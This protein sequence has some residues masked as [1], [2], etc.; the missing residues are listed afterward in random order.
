MV[1]F[2]TWHSEILRDMHKMYKAQRKNPTFCRQIKDDRHTVLGYNTINLRLLKSTNVQ[3]FSRYKI[4]NKNY[5]NTTK[6]Y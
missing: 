5:E 6:I 3:V 2:E 1:K 4:K